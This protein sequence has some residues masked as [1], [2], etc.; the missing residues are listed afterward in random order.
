MSRVQSIERAFAVLGALAD[1]P[2]GRDRGRRSRPACPKS[3]A[4]RLLAALAARGRRRAGPG[5]HAATGSGRGLVTLAARARGRRAS[6][7]ASPARRSTSSRPSVRRG[8]RAVRPATAT[9]STT[10]TR[11]SH[12]RTR[13]RSATGPARGSRCT[14]CRP[15]RCCSPFRPPAL[16][17]RYLARPLER[18]T[19]RT[20]IDR[21]RAAASGC[22]R[23]GATATRGSLEEFDEGIASVAAPDRRRVAARSS[24][25]STSTGRRTGSRPRRRR[26]S[27]RSWSA[28]GP[29]RGGACAAPAGPAAV[30]RAATPGAADHADPRH[31]LHPLFMAP[32]ASW[33]DAAR[34]TR[35]AASPLPPR[36]PGVPAEMAFVLANHRRRS[37]AAS[38]L[39][40]E[41]AGTAALVGPAA[42]VRRLARRDDHHDG[43]RRGPAGRS[44]CRASPRPSRRA[45]RRRRLPLA[46]STGWHRA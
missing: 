3:T 18:F 2:L 14:R 29:D 20:L 31:R 16:V 1:G 4:A 44:P 11:S 28:R 35:S 27:P 5:R 8:G 41:R 30:D 15:A 26:R 24:P 45:R 21:R 12:A 43:L 22:A 10:S 23:S 42:R 19:P 17:Q 32:A 13:S 9:S 36:S 38:L 7:A 40:L 46:D 6:L 39:V 34:P 37:L 25:R 33:A